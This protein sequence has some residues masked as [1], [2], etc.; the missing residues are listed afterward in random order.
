MEADIAGADLFGFFDRKSLERR[1]KANL[2][3]IPVVITDISV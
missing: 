3:P 1:L 2:D